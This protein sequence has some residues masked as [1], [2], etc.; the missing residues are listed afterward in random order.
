MIQFS[1][2]LGL[3]G[4]S[5]IAALNEQKGLHRPRCYMCCL[6][7]KQLAKVE[8][9]IQERQTIKTAWCALGAVTILVCLGNGGTVEQS[10]G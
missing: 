4:L 7:S 1:V 3:L 8:N 6:D 2:T 10:K 9:R 5:F